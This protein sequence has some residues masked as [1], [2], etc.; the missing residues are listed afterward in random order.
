VPALGVSTRWIERRKPHWDRLEALVVA[1]DRQGVGAL[2]RAD[3][4][5]LASLYR[6]TAA[7]LSVVRDDRSAGDLARYL[8]TLLGRA[9]NLIYAGDQRR[10]R[11]IVHFYAR[12]FPAVFRATLPYTLT[13]FAI[14][15]AGLAGGAAVTWAD[16]GFSRLFLGGTMLDTI[17][18]GEMWTHSIVGIKPLASSAIMSNNLSVS[19]AAFAGGIFGGVG[20]VYMM[21]FNGVLIGVLAVACERAGM[22]LSLWSFVAPHG[23]LELPAIFIA[24]GA[25]LLLAKGVLAPG[26]LSR[27]DSLVESASIA[28]RLVL[29]VIPLLVVAGTIEG[30]VSPTDLAP[31]AKFVLGASL[32]VLLVAYV[33]LVPGSEPGSVA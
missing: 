10:P 11:G 30:F 20:T 26:F 19:F 23:S 32:F 17:E 2:G 9:H 15:L 1:C 33:T 21:L 14:F 18:R 16:P 8:N 27:R 31:S 4:R 29:G 22:S 28:V 12:V 3:L 7:D 25:G 24:G 6:Q 13:A 5:E